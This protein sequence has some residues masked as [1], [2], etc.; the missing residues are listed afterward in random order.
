LGGTTI[1]ANLT[2]NHSHFQSNYKHKAIDLT[3]GEPFVIQDIELPIPVAPRPTQNTNPRHEMLGKHLENNDHGCK[4]GFN[5][6]LTIF[7]NK[8][9]LK[10]A[11][12]GSVLAL[13]VLN[14]YIVIQ[15][16][17]TFT[18]IFG[19]TVL[20]ILDFTLV[21]FFSVLM[22]FYKPNHGDFELLTEPSKMPQYI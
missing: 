13:L 12:L 21:T 5:H 16:L 6:F 8:I 9:D 2:D 15:I 20:L 10:F 7:E 17:L 14:Y 19:Y 11:L 3:N 1:I 22:L 4:S 18:A